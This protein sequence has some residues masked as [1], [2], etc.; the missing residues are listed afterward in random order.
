VH[1][2]VPPVTKPRLIFWVSFGLFNNQNSKR[3]PERL[4]IKGLNN[5]NNS[6]YFSALKYVYRNYIK[7]S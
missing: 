3:L 1:R 7:F 2:A 6:K 4:E 5:E